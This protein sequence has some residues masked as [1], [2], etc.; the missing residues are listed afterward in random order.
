MYMCA[1][2][3]TPTL[4]QS[5][6]QIISTFFRPQQGAFAASMSSATLPLLQKNYGAAKPLVDADPWWVTSSIIRQNVNEWLI[7]IKYALSAL[8]LADHWSLTG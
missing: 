7:R 4:S 1:L 8:L 6:A 5:R 2:G 3:F